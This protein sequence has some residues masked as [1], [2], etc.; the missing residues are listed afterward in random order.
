MLA[1]ISP[2]EARVNAPPMPPSRI[3][4]GRP[5]TERVE[6]KLAPENA[7]DRTLELGTPVDNFFCTFI[8]FPQL[9]DSGRNLI[10]FLHSE[11][12]QLRIQTRIFT[13]C[14]RQYV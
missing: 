8:F 11:V 9:T 7:A 4:A 14:G 5:T 1:I 2:E 12:Q 3:V 13:R 6:P 10:Y